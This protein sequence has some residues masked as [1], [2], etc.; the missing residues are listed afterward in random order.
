MDG[1]FYLKDLG[2]TYGTW[3]AGGQRLA[4]NQAVQLKKGDRFYLASEQEL[5]Q[6]TGK[7]SI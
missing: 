2:S 1:K 6:I 4:A 5:Y 7:G 3:L